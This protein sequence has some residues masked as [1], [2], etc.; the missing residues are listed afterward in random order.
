MHIVWPCW[1]TI[2]GVVFLVEHS[3]SILFCNVTQ[4]GV[5]FLWIKLIFLRGSFFTVFRIKRNGYR[6]DRL[7]IFF[8]LK[9]LYIIITFEY[10]FNLVWYHILFSTSTAKSLVTR[11]KNAFHSFHHQMTSIYSKVREHFIQRT[12]ATPKQKVCLITNWQ[13]ICFSTQKVF[14]NIIDMMEIRE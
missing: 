2:C 3:I 11:L 7:P 14:L 4:Y 8:Y 5:I 6:M 9:V 12:W 10:I 13:E 1:L